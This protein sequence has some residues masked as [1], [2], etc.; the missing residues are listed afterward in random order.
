MLLFV[1]SVPLMAFLLYFLTLISTITIRWQ[2]RETAVVVSRGMRSGQ[3]LLVG[4][5]ESIVLI[6]IG[7]PLGILSGIE[8]AQLMGYTQSFMSFVLRDPLPISPTAFNPWMVAV[9][10]L[11]TLLARLGPIWRASRRRRY[12][13]SAGQRHH[14]ARPLWSREHSSRLSSD[15]WRRPGGWSF[16]SK[17][18]TSSVGRTRISC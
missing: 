9:A 7:G 12:A 4:L 3:L 17:R 10:V 1:F 16:I 13:P 14:G 2:R 5:I 6:G 15:R 8:L 18:A 11:A